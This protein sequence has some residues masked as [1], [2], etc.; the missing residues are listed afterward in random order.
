MVGAFH[1]HSTYSDGTGDVLH[2]LDAARSAGVDFVVLTDHDTLA[3]RREEWEG[4]HDGVL[5]IV[6]CEVTPRRRG[7]C[8]ALGVGECLGYA[9]Q[10]PKE[11]LDGI[12]RQHGKAIVAHPMGERKRAFRI[13]HVPWSDWRHPAVAGL[14]IWSYMHDWIADLQFWRLHEYYSFCRH[15]ERKIT[16]PHPMVLRM[17]DEMGKQRRLAG[18]SGLDCHAREVPFTE[19]KLFPYDEMFRTLCT[20]V[21]VDSLKGENSRPGDRGDPARMIEA[22][23]LGRAFVAYDLIGDSRGTR[24]WAECG[25]GR[26]IELGGEHPAHDTVRF[27]LGLPEQACRPRR[28]AGTEHSQAEMRLLRDG[29]PCACAEGRA[30]EHEDRRPGVYRF[31]VRLGGR[32]WIFTNPFYLRKVQCRVG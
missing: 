16:G 12:H 22:L 11:F 2:I 19:I 7:H 18:V 3:A 20:H 1:V 10:E 17:W 14:E 26:R 31:E 25:C 32:P 28:G 24:A 4:W 15:P 8:V 23:T 6:G 13:H 27:H 5:L 29:A 9:L 30:L 21:L